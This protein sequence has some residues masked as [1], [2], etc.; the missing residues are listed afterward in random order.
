L[1]LWG[2]LPDH[3]LF[4]ETALMGY[5]VLL[6]IFRLSWGTCAAALL[7]ALFG[8]RPPLSHMEIKKNVV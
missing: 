8:W 7:G 4:A 6:S 5:F 2:D 1:K 3:F